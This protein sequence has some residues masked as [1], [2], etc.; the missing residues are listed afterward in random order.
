MPRRRKRKAAAE[1]LPPPPKKRKQWSN[2]SM[3]LAMEAVKAGRLGVNEAARTY[4]LPCST[5]KDHLK[6]K[7]VHGTNPGPR[8]FLDEVEEKSLTEHLIRAAQL[9][10]GKT[11]KQVLGMVE[12]VAREK[13][14]L[15]PDRKKLSSGW[16]R[17]FMQR[18]PK[19][20]LR[21]GDSTAHV[22]MDCTNSAA[23]TN[24]F[25]LLEKYLE[26]VGSPAQIYNMDESGIPLDPHPPNIVTK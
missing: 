26:K 6:G 15:Q 12:N 14:I 3:V 7:V 25:N 9:G 23:L 22:R 13:G 4:G 5:L 1:P 2:D 8:P 21:R 17:R 19:L 20:S 24:Y 10:Y 11:R 18:N 16:F